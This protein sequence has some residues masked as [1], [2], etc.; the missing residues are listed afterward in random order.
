MAPPIEMQV[1]PLGDRLFKN[2]IPWARPSAEFERLKNM[3]EA[4]EWYCYPDRK[5]WWRRP[6]AQELGNRCIKTSIHPQVRRRW[7]K[8]IAKNYPPAVSY[9]EKYARHR[10]NACA[11]L[12]SQEHTAK[13]TRTFPWWRESHACSA[14]G[15]YHLD[16]LAK[17]DCQ[18]GCEARY[19]D[20]KCKT[21]DQSREGGCKSACMSV[22]HVQ[23]I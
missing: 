3:V 21:H 4:A 6:S 5:G 2:E 19:C 22:D 18:A 23:W 11:Y 7:V 8:L 14:C 13:P 10:V 20:N 9:A 17:C 15:Y 1:V 16:C 12:K